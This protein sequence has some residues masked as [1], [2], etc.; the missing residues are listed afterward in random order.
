M[1]NK[2]TPSDF[3]DSIERQLSGLKP[4]PWLAQRIIASE[5]EEPK[6]KKLSGI[7][8][9]IVIIMILIMTTA[10]A[11][12]VT[13]WFRR[14]VN[15]LGEVVNEDGIQM[16]PSTPTPEMASSTPTPEMASSTPNPDAS[17]T[18][19]TDPAKLDNL[20][21]SIMNDREDRELVVVD[22][23]YTQRIQEFSSIEEFRSLMETASDFPLPVKIPDGYQ[24]STGYVTFGCKPEGEFI[25]TSQTKHPEGFTESRYR[26]DESMDF[27]IGYSLFFTADDWLG[28]GYGDYISVDANMYPLSDL[29]EYSTGLR[30]NET[31]R[32]IKIE[33][34][35]NALLIES[36]ELNRLRMRKVMAEP[37]D[38][39]T[40]DFGN[41]RIC[42]YGEYNVTVLATK[43][44]GD[45]LIAVFSK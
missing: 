19:Q 13:G 24:F 34:V 29:H 20:I 21:F 41:Q 44:S 7:T 27:I 31:S 3:H 5:K 35:E 28:A 40:F 32:V 10:V 37:V 14:S 43:L 38:D 8:I 15:W 18:P 12:G 6:V 25:L 42:T 17:S 26:V 22:D 1:K 11:A 33:G 2:I 45:D 23:G 39:L 16:A 9:A 30:E 4:D 36:D